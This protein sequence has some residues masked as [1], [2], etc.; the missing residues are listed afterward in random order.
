MRM[1]KV[2]NFIVRNHKWLNCKT[3]LIELEAPGDLPEIHAGNF[4][5]IAIP[6]SPKVFLRRPYSVYDAD[7]SSNTLKF[8]IK[9][10]GEGSR[11]LGE[12]KI[13]D[14]LNLIYPLGNSFSIP[15]SGR[16]LVIA[17]GTGIAPFVLFGKE[18]QKSRVDITF[19]FG[20]R[21]AEEIVLTE[22]FNIY[23]DVL[24]T[25]EDGSLGEK[26]LVTQHSIF[27]NKNLPFDFIVTCGPDLM[28]KA[29]GKIAMKRNIKCEA[30]LE[31]SMACGFGA[32]LCCVV[33]TTGGN[34]CV[35][36]E[37]PVFNV[38]DLKW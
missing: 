34:K 16:I 30:S 18:L 33:A 9:V 19:L 21:S 22:Q 1:K 27:G 8:F 26:G 14:S 38:N 20:A 32:C 37:G 2:E 36:T 23:G 11:T 31:N 25:T 35:C 7:L 17:G 29:V 28:M 12:I 3:F 6:N 4:A 10:I 5:E 13:G 24:V 15:A